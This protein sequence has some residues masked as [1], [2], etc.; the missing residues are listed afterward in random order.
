MHTYIY[1]YYIQYIT[2]IALVRRK[3]EKGYSIVY[4][5]DKSLIIDDAVI[6]NAFL[7]KSCFYRDPL[8]TFLLSVPQ[9]VVTFLDF[10]VLILNMKPGTVYQLWISQLSD[11]TVLTT[12]IMSQMMF[13]WLTQY[14]II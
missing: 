5:Y 3:L 7:K 12:M 4:I 10:Y 6:W 2:Y 11:F 13:P 14:A 9:F 1:T 8:V